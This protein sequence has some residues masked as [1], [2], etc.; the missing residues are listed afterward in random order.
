MSSCF[1][2]GRSRLA[3]L[4]LI[5][6]VAFAISL[7]AS[8]A[9][10]QNVYTNI[11]MLPEND[12]SINSSAKS[13]DI[14]LD[15]K[16]G[17]IYDTD[18][19]GMESKNGVVDFTVENSLFSFNA[20][21]SKLCTIWDIYSIEEKKSTD[22][23]SGAEKCCSFIGIQQKSSSWN[24][25]FYLTPSSGLETES[26]LVSAKIIYYDG[27]QSGIINSKWEISKAIFAGEEASPGLMQEI[28]E[29][30]KSRNTDLDSV[31][32]I[33]NAN[34]IANPD[35]EMKIVFEISKD[36]DKNISIQLENFKGELA[37]WSG[38]ENIIVE[39][40]NSKLEDSLT[41]LGMKPTEMVS[42]KGLE[43]FIGEENYDGIVSVKT[44]N[45]D[46]ILYCGDD[47]AVRCQEV[48]ECGIKGQLC[49]SKDGDFV[50]V[51]V[52]HFSSVVF[53]LDSTGINLTSPDATIQSG[54]NAYLNFTANSTITANYSID[55][56]P[57][58]AL[59]S[60]TS[61]S[62][63]MSPYFEN[64]V[65]RNGQHNVTIEIGN[66]GNNQFLNYSFIVNDTTA[67]GLSLNVQ[68]NSVVSDNNPQIDAVLDEYGAI[69]YKVN[70]NPY[71]TIN[72]TSSKS[73]SFV[74]SLSPGLNLL[75]IN[76]SDLQGN[77]KIETYSINYGTFSCSDGM[78]NGDETGIDCGGSCQAC[79]PF[80]A[81]TD[82]PAYNS[83]DNV[84][85]TVSAR[86]NST[87]DVKISREN[88]IIF[89]HI[90]IPVFNG[91]PIL[92]TRIVGNTNIAGIYLV[93]ATMAYLNTTQN[94]V[95]Y[96]Q[97]I[98]SSNTLSVDININSSRIYEDAEV[99]F[100]AIVTGNITGTT[101][102]WDFNND[103]V[104]D[105]TKSQEIYKYASN[106]TYKVNL[107]VSDSQWN[108]SAS[109]I[110]EVE[111][112]FSAKILVYDNDTSQIVQNA[113][114][115]I[116]EEYLNTSASG[117]VTFV[118]PKGRYNVVIKKQG[119]STFSNKTDIDSNAEFQYRILPLDLTPPSI[120]FLE[121]ADQFPL[122]ESVLFHFRASD[123]LMMACRLFLKSNSSGFRVVLQNT[124]VISGIDTYFNYTSFEDEEYQWKI[125][126]IDRN[127]NNMTSATRNIVFPTN[128]EIQL[129]EESVQEES[130]VK[131]VGTD[132]IAAIEEALI[133]IENYGEDE[134]D[135]ADAIGLQKLLEKARTG[136]QRASRDIESLQYRQLNGTDL[137]Q[138]TQ[139]IY[140]RIDEIKRTTPLS[141]SIIEK[142]DFVKYPEK[143]DVENALIVLAN[144][145]NIRLTRKDLN[146]LSQEAYKLQSQL[147]V[148]TKLMVAEVTYVTGEV[149]Y[150]SI[151]QKNVA[152]KSKN[153]GFVFYEVIPKEIAS[154]IS[155]INADFE[156]TKI[157]EDP[158]IEINLEKIQS[159]SYYISKRLSPIEAESIKSILLDPNIK[160]SRKNGLTGFSIL[161]NFTS[162]IGKTI[163]IRFSIEASIIVILTLVFLYYQ[164]GE[165]KLGPMLNFSSRKSI[166]ELNYLFEKIGKYLSENR[167]NDSKTIYKE[168]E[169]IFRKLP[170]NI[171]A[172]FFK[173]VM[174]CH[175]RMNF[176]FIDNLLN[177]A[178]AS[179]RTNRKLAVENYKKVIS[180]YKEISKEYKAKIHAKCM[181]L[182]TLLN[183]KEEK[184][185]E[186]KGTVM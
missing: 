109:K 1:V 68:N 124:S 23:C 125:E 95:S 58:V 13:I 150:I 30:I 54:E 70:N 52:P 90:F 72:M 17:T 112:R 9:N 73:S 172:S 113:E 49:Y 44:S 86:M 18:D 53:I 14:A 56:N 103:G 10:A 136:I 64:S 132:S 169:S 37:N 62:S 82:R 165:D 15:Y 181:E 111:K 94:L 108:Q 144:R 143:E 160:A 40:T 91:A 55:K 11:D 133:N 26:N 119:Y 25:I 158:I 92:E 121:P 138:E 156:Y 47:N 22:S 180:V 31:Q 107:S 145:S 166:K 85:L 163:D 69:S 84:L 24:G 66:N 148:T 178:I 43:S 100:T 116:E 182:N 45:Y 34:Q 110:I 184:K 42:L 2:S 170:K 122:D 79:I 137:D 135:A 140:D 183:S 32:I 60:G 152:S 51:F 174:D 78:Q 28:A 87:V 128:E 142:N 12:K 77:Y 177:E 35:D 147:T 114:V 141:I 76:S 155:E 19:D 126:C 61:F 57:V 151:I 71:T 83:T 89:S 186:K 153:D 101:Y 50:N 157:Q 176:I 75:T 67:P 115:K 105:S 164:F 168:I 149:G 59:G 3:T 118:V 102:K 5:I 130:S 29:K 8:Y 98:G 117:D 16:S 20:D 6:F 162:G 173:K 7:I 127:G 93:N 104:I 146:S 36:E 96:F 33:G 97:V 27:A 80:T 38:A 106:G 46:K 120:D 161:N 175:N 81:A 139:K 131:E 65:M 129:T 63:L 21:T 123:K 159:Y 185:E 48:Q 4:I 154:N 74:A 88:S 134:K 39:T 167:Y 41:G 171:K 99:I 179:I